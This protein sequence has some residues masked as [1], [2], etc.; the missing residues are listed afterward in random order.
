MIDIIDGNDVIKVPNELTINMYQKMSR[1]PELYSNNSLELIGLMTNLPPNKLKN[2]SPATIKLLNEYLM[3]KIGIPNERQLV[4]TFKHNDV[5]YGLEQ[6]FTKLA[7]G[8][9]VDLEV[10]SSE[11]ISDNI[12]KLMSILY[13]PITKWK[14]KKYEIEPYDADTINER[15]EIF[16][17]LPISYWFHV[18]DFFLSVANLSITNIRTSLERKTKWNKLMKRGMMTLPRWLQKKLQLGSTL[19]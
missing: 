16:L 3:T 13:R 8:A 10:Y 1:D 18:S 5:E 15:A 14:G 6:D 11:N 9:W 4:L 7:W 2:C 17:D 19:S 12:H